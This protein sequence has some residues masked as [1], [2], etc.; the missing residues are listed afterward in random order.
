MKLYLFVAASVLALTSPFVFSEEPDLEGKQV[1]QQLTDR[2]EKITK[3]STEEQL[4]LRAA[5]VKASEDPEVLAALA[6]R[7]K[8]IEEFRKAMHD[9]MVKSDPKV[10]EI[11]QKIAVGTSPGF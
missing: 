4:K 6:K 8:A 7:D 10:E 3:L 2:Q 5:Q 1:N 11:L 9:S